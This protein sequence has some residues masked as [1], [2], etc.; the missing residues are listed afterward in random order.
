MFM[1]KQVGEYSNGRIRLLDYIVLSV[2]RPS[3]TIPKSKMSAAIQNT[4]LNGAQPVQPFQ[5]LIS[6]SKALLH[7]SR[8]QRPKILHTWRVAVINYKS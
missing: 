5:L 2:K 4:T 6:Q 7:I 1:S 3:N 8:E